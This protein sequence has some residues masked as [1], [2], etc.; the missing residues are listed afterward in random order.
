MKRSNSVEW[1]VKEFPVEIDSGS[2]LIQATG[3]RHTDGTHGILEEIDRRYFLV[4][5]P[6][7]KKRD[8]L[9]LSISDDFMAEPFQRFREPERARVRQILD[10]LNPLIK[11]L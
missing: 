1:W 9:T 6:N 4:S 3:R 10:E 7:P 11:S 2:E 8:P 5:N